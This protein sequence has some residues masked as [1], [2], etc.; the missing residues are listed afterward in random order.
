[1]AGDSATL[2]LHLPISHYPIVLPPEAPRLP[3][4]PPESLERFRAPLKDRRG[5]RWVQEMFARH[6]R[7]A[8]VAAAA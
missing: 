2:L 6:R 1:M 5:Y 3:E 8:A 7:P 4:G